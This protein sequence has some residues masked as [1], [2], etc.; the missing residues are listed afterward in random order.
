MGQQSGFDEV[1]ALKEMEE[2]KVNSS[3]NNLNATSVTIM[4]DV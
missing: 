3:A 4:Q 1:T 2:S